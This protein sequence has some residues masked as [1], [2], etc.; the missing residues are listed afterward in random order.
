MSNTKNPMTY[1]E[2]MT[3]LKT[4]GCIIPDEEFCLKTLQS[5]NYYRLSAYFL[6]F[7]NADD[8]F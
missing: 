4:R 6:L 2:Q 8:S 7:K 3:L 5:V 1:Q